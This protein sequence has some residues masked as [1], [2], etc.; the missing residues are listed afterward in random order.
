MESA[1][2]KERLEGCVHVPERAKFLVKVPT[3]NKEICG[4]GFGLCI[5]CDI[6]HARCTDR[7][8]SRWDIN[9]K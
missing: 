7:G 6:V 5:I 9:I 2:V 3:Y 1:C 8:L 4:V